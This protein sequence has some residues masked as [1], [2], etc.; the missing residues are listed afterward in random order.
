MGPARAA[1]GF[2]TPADRL[3]NELSFRPR[4]CD[5]KH[6]PF[7]PDGSAQGEDG[8]EIGGGDGH[9]AAVT[10]TVEAGAQVGE[11]GGEA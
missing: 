6:L 3:F 8:L 7:S 1:R 4:P 5:V 2:D 10:V 11:V 9:A